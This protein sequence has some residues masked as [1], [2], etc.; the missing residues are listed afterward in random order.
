MAVDYGAALEP[1]LLS[2]M[3]EIPTH[4]HIGTVC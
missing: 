1:E 3:G 4:L 2:G